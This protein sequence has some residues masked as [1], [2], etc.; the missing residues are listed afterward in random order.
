MNQIESAILYSIRKA[1]IF[2]LVVVFF[3]AFFV[4]LPASADA[5]GPACDP[6]V[7]LIHNGSF[8]SPV[9]TDPKKWD[10]IPWSNSDLMWQSTNPGYGL[11]IQAGYTEDALPWAPYDGSQYAELDFRNESVFQDIPSHTGYTYKISFVY[12]PRPHQ[13]TAVNVL[14]VRWNNTSLENLVA[15]GSAN[16]NTVWTAREYSVVAANSTSTFAFMDTA[17]ASA[18][19]GVGMFMDKVSIRCISAPANTPPVITLIGQNPAT[20]TVGVPYNDPGATAADT[21]DGN[22]TSHIATTSTINIAV[23]GTYAITYSVTDS[24]GLS[25]STTRTVIV[26]PEMY[27]PHMPSCPAGNFGKVT[28]VF[29]PA[30]YDY[31]ITVDNTP[32]HYIVYPVSGLPAGDYLD[33]Y[34]VHPSGLGNYVQWDLGITTKKVRVFVVPDHG[35]YPDEYMEYGVQVSPDGTTWVAASSTAVYVDD[36][37]N[38]RTHDGV[39]DFVSAPFRYVRI[40]PNGVS[41]TDYEIDAVQACNDL[42]VSGGANL[43]VTKTADKSTANVG[44]TIVYAIGL[45]NN[46]P[47]GAASVTVTDIFPSASLNFVSATSTVGSYSTTT[48]IWTIG[49]MA[50]GSS[51]T[52]TLVT[53][54]KAGTEGQ[55]ITNS[56]IASSTVADPDPGDNATSTDVTVNN[57]S[58]NHPP[59]ITLIGQNP[60]TTTV[61]VPY[62]DPGATAA[63]TEDGNLT[64]H[65]ATTSTINIAVP[66]TY[67]ITYSVTDSGGLSASTTRTVIVLPEMYLPHMPSCP[68]GN[69]GKVTTV[70]NP[71]AYDYGITVD[72]TPEHY[73]VY[74]VSGLPAGDYLDW[75]WVHPSGLGNYV[76]WDLGITT[77]KVR[78]FVVPDHGPY[79]DEYMEYGV[80]VSP[81]GTTWVAASSTA[82]YV[83]DI[84]NV[85][86]HDGVQDFVSAPFR[87]VR[88]APN[89]VSGTDYEID[90]VQACNDLPVSGG[91]NLKVTKTADK[92]TAN[93]G[94]TIV[95]AI[96]LKNNGPQG[97]ASVTVTDIFPSASLNFVSATS[98]VG[99]YSTT[100]NIWTIG[101][102]A[103]G[104]STTLTLVT[105]VKAGTEGQK[106]TNSAIASSTVAD[107]DPGD[108]A[109]STDVTVN[110]QS[111]NHPPVI[112]L[113]GQNPATTTVGVPYNDPGA[114]AADTEDGNLTSHIATSSTVNIAVPGT[115]GITYSV[116]D[117]G[118]LS[119]STTRTVIVVPLG[120]GA[121]LKVTKTADKST[122]NV[123]DTIVYA[124]GLKNN[125]PQTAASTTVTDILP[126][127]LTFVSATSTQGLYN[128][129]TG[130]WT[131]GALANGSSTALSLVTTVKTGTEG[132]KITNSAIASSTAVDS[133]PSDNTTSTDVTI[134]TP[135]T[136]CVSNCG[137]GGGGGGGGG[138]IS[139]FISNERVVE[140]TPGIATVT[141]DTNLSA[142]R[143]VVYGTAGFPGAGGGN[144]NYGYATST[145][146]IATPLLTSHSMTIPLE[147]G[148]TYYFRPVSTDSLRS[149]LGNELK[150]TRGSI[151]G[152]ETP[153]AA[154][155]YL[156]DYLRK[157][158]NN[159]PVEVKKLQIFLKT[160]EGFKNLAVTDVYDDATIAAIDAFQIKYSNEVL[161]PWGYGGAVGTDY[162]YILTRKKVN[163]IYCRHAFPVDAQQQAEIDATRAF[164][165][166]LKNAGI[167]VGNA[168][169]SATSTN[170]GIGTGAG[171]DTQLQATL[172]TSSDLNHI[173]SSANGQNPVSRL[174]GNIFN[175]GAAVGSRMFAFVSWPFRSL[176]SIFPWLNHIGYR[177]LVVILVI[178]ALAWLYRYSYAKSNGKNRTDTIDTKDTPKDPE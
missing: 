34:W 148:K 86:T 16:T 21:E 121:N 122:A 81:D 27:L 103:S 110:N 139:L 58:I 53:T 169:S 91:A 88:I 120:G 54:V 166:S 101:T 65:I 45:K 63:D 152:G 146:L 7:E 10:I 64:S 115:Y 49:T 170:S 87:Y 29:N 90:A 123:G 73:I 165:E 79:P 56:A 30:A 25:A 71:A 98:T 3:I 141:W 57:Q 50:S 100:T 76:Q 94:D 153:A 140:T 132:Q 149:A 161:A 108:N 156:R 40:A 6:S 17:A 172:P 109:T 48:N 68:A 51:T 177:I 24:G 116:T 105:T 157:D 72:N 163:E 164:F 2:T 32:E 70:F 174:S 78:V 43:K 160:L 41:G 162:T 83:D 89:G 175:A 111:I 23:P 95:Y 104:S 113:I 147:P 158:F 150:L 133:D 80:Q 138:L 36:I 151:G 96:G 97:A 125:G 59:V 112:T 128:T 39:Q 8:E 144:P 114:T 11:E 47:Q 20:T 12:S 119:A 46:G 14:D 130:I 131:V 55:K 145:D 18:P 15:D 62:N 60:A 13:N 143:R 33:W 154:C 176:G 178:G 99:S 173:S 37:H 26:L 52:L 85:R 69:F 117:S 124:I 134:N 44:D 4:V 67:A 35:P 142:T 31:G 92:S 137:G 5:S 126:A 77:K 159:N 38:V 61:G 136:G 135:T 171:I 42:P 9:I 168:T 82:V 19:G 1:A 84:H 129:S 118:G 127:G 28:T 75:Y 93:V 155:Y 102:M 22:L 74:P 106:I 66:G 167:G 107:P